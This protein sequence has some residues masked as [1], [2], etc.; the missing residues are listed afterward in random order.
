MNNGSDFSSSLIASIKT[1]LV[2]ILTAHSRGI[3]KRKNP[4]TTNKHQNRKRTSQ[5]SPNGT[6]IF[7]A[8]CYELHPNN[9][10]TKNLRT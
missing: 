6:I 10:Q 7:T 8:W 9:M 4:A 5:G 2:S 3:V 1:F